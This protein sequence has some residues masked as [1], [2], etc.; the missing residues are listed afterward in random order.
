MFQ[1]KE[2]DKSSEANLNEIEICNLPNIKFKRIV[3]KMLTEVRT[4]IYEQRENFQQEVESTLKVPNR[5]HRAEE[6]NN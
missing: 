6:Y 1:I 2:Q 4:A 5:N 3:I